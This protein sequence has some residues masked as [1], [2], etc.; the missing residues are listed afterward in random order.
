MV[1]SCN[2]TLGSFLRLRTFGPHSFGASAYRHVGEMG[3][4]GACRRAGDRRTWPNRRPW[5][6]RHRP[7]PPAPPADDVDATGTRPFARHASVVGGGSRC[8]GTWTPGRRGS[9]LGLILSR[10]DISKITKVSC[11][12]PHSMSVRELTSA[13]RNS[14]DG[15]FA[16]RIER[17]IAEI[18]ADLASNIRGYKC[19]FGRCTRR[20]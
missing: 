18:S 9:Q 7:G 4:V 1:G 6:V 2:S 10:P 8:G 13:R 19:H 3:H 15:G 17:R 11:L 14:M 20:D 12:R 16:V 5:P